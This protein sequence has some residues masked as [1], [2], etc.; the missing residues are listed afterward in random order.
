MSET[1]EDLKREARETVILGYGLRCKICKETIG[2]EAEL[3][4]YRNK[5][6]GLCS[7]CAHKKSTE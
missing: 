4:S 1:P 6:A 2:T 5:S 7:K 3:E